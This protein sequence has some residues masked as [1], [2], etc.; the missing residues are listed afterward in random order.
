MSGPI[1]VLINRGGG[2]AASKGDKLEAEII[3]AFAKAGVEID[4]QLVDGDELEGAAKAVAGQ[5]L[6]VV[7][8]GDGTLGRLA[9]ILA[10]K[11]STLG[12]LPLGTRNHLARELG[13]PLDLPGAAALIAAGTVRAIDLARVNGEP[14]INNASIGLYPQ[15][16]RERDQRN[17][18]KWIAA[19]PATF[20]AL[21][22]I[23]HHRLHLSVPGPTK[24]SNIVTPMLFVGNN[25]Y[26]LD[27]GQ[28]GKRDALDGGIL[29]IYAV[30]ARRR[31]ALIGFAIRTLIG[32]ARRD[33][34]FAA[35]G[36]PPGFEV[37]GRSEDIDIALDGEVITLKMPL[38]FECQ[39][40]ALKVLA[41]AG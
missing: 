33:S 16:V 28:I 18:P 3:D 15:L 35:I 6:V 26:T 27:A 17:T 34:D 13:V 14:F 25:H 24:D 19:I 40:G 36:D 22:R 4:L 9:G 8:G 1:P 10:D 32:R 11:G 31:L 38:R 7:G 39:A 12:I 29:S 20:A 41:P 2:T 23:Q 21:S 37:S 5:P 30:A